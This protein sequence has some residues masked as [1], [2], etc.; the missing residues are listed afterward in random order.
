LT[1]DSR[2]YSS[3]A[4]TLPPPSRATSRPNRPSR[5]GARMALSDMW[6]WWHLYLKNSPPRSPAKASTTIRSAVEGLDHH[7]VG[8][9]SHREV[10]LQPFLEFGFLHHHH[11]SNHLR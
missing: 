11:A 1:I 5:L 2:M 9:P 10:L 6:H 4:K 7:P 3:S 8:G